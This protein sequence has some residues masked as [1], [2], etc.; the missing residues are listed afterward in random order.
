M[1][2][3]HPRVKMNQQYYINKLY[4]LNNKKLNTKLPINYNSY[5]IKELLGKRRM[6]ERKYKSNLLGL[7]L[8]IK[9]R[10]K[11][12][13]RTRKIQQHF[14]SIGPNSFNKKSQTNLT[15]IYTK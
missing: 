6:N 2:Q 13:R 10:L 12:V 4:K 7:R 3:I 11:G 8:V 14:G 9:G 1:V 15:N 5:S